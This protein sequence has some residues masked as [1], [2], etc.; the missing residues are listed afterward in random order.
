MKLYPSTK[1]FENQLRKSAMFSPICCF[2]LTY[3]SLTMTLVL[4][5]TP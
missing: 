4:F 5:S 1:L 2:E 3:M